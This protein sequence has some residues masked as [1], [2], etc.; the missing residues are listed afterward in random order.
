MGQH[1]HLN[2]I[3]ELN[4]ALQQ[5]A[6]KHPLIS[7]VDFSQVDDRFEPGTRVSTNF[8][9]IMFKNY[10]ANKIKYGRKLVDFDEGH[11]ICMAPNQVVVFDDQP[12][13]RPN[14]MGWGL[15]FHPDLI[16]GSALGL[17]IKNYSFFSYET[18]EALHLSEKEW[19]ILSDCVG[20]IADEIQEN[21]DAYS[22]SLMV[23][24]LELLLNYCNRFYGRQF[25]TR[26]SVNHEV[27]SAVEGYLMACF[28]DNGNAL[29]TVKFIAEKVNLSAGYLSDLL[30]RETGMNAQDHIHYAL[31]QEA[32]NRLMGTRH[33]VSEI[34]FSLGFEYPQYFSKL[35]KQKTGLSPMEYR[36]LN[37]LN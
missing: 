35:F 17:N 28:A 13:N 31:I 15:F 14:K 7:V 34:A 10:C 27:V 3:S 36:G 18:H 2:S 16:R 5:E 6:A 32:K 30:K 22:Q 24:N 12:V 23:S 4:R 1:L 11:L 9:S 33:S 29:P 26:K 19:Q 21:I 8:Y 25:I 37:S 20:K